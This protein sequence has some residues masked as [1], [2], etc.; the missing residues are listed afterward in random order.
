MTVKK[1]N[2]P[3]KPPFSYY[4]GK[5]RIA[6]KIIPYIPRHTIYAEPFCGAATLL[7]AKK[8]PSTTRAQSD[9][10]EFI[11]DTNSWVT[12]FF[13][14]LLHP[15]K[16]HELMS[17][18]ERT[19][20]T[21]DNYRE[22]VEAYKNDTF[23]DDIDK[24][25][26]LFYLS[27]SSYCNKL[28][29]GFAYGMKDMNNVSRFRLKVEAL[30]Q[31]PSRISKLHV[32]NEDALTFIKRLDRPY[33]FLYVD[34]PYPGTSQGH[35]SGYTIEDYKALLQAL[36]KTQASFILSCYR[37]GCEPE[38]WK[39]IDI[40]SHT[41][42]PRNKQSEKKRTETIWI[43]DRG[44]AINDKYFNRIYRQDSFVKIWGAPDAI[45]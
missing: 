28:A 37:Q 33:V 29:S 44:G 42:A 3:K 24:A 13:E 12:N 2:N 22:C 31:Y 21:Q 32:F 25:Y 41:S 17:R 20:Y 1:K 4:G 35:Y 18:L 30:A 19:L 39:S 43:V 15:V 23:T 6:S 9:Y 5:Q 7:F 11:N 36:D 38:H 27:F 8:T 14:V 45:K 34:P 10:M 26:V 16:S 40:E